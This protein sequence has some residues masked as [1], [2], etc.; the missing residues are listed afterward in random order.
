MAMSTAAALRQALA[1]KR[2]APRHH[3][4]AG[5]SADGGMHAKP[6]SKRTVRTDPREIGRVSAF[7]KAAQA[8]RATAE[9][10]RLIWP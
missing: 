4:D 2:A 9:T 8:R 1:R 7:V 3:P 10:A 6:S 5:V